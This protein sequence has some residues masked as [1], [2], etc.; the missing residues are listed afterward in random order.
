[1]IVFKFGKKE[2]IRKF[3]N[4]ISS[5]VGEF[6][7]AKPHPKSDFKILNILIFG[8][9][10]SGKSSFIN[11]CHTLLNDYSGNVISLEVFEKKSHNMQHFTKIPLQYKGKFLGFQIWDWGLSN[12]SYNSDVLEKI[13]DGIIPSN[14]KMDD[15]PEDQLENIKKGY[16]SKSNRTMHS[17]LFFVLWS[18]IPDQNA[19]QERKKMKDSFEKMN[20][21]RTQ[22]NFS[23]YIS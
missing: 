10:G 2:K 11:G 20:Q 22:S 5:F 13:M 12:Q 14:W 23:T 7:N 21:K 8:W 6:V 19:N 17:V 16:E 4:F 3:Q 18:T 9:F 15:L 1:M